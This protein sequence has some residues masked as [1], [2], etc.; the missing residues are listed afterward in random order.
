MNKPTHRLKEIDILAGA[1]QFELD[2]HRSSG[3][4]AEDCIRAI[5]D[6]M[7]Y[8]TEAIEKYLEETGFDTVGNPPKELVAAE[9]AIA[10]RLKKE[11]V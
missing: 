10:K 9:K 2:E 4:S 11:K 8:L 5:E 3:L 7:E 6:H 1:I